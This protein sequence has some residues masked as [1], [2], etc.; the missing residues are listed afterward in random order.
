MQGKLAVNTLM[1]E[2]LWQSETWYQS[3]VENARDVIYTVSE[4]AVIT[5]L[6]P[7]FERITGWPP[8]E[9]IGKPLQS[10]VHPDD[11]PKELELLEHML[12]GRTPPVHE[13]RVRSNS[14]DYWTGEFMITPQFEDGSFVGVVGVGRD[15]T[16]RKRMEEELRIKE[17]AIASSMNAIALADLEGN[18]TYVNPAFL[19][20][21]GYDNAEEVLGKP[22]AKFWKA[23]EHTQAITDALFHRT[24]WRGELVARR[25]D[26]AQCD[27]HVSVNMIEG[28]AGKPLCM[29]SSCVDITEAKRVGR[30]L[31]QSEERY[32]ELVENMTDAIYSIDSEGFITY[33][34]PAIE[35]ILGYH[36]SEMVGRAL[37][38][39]VYREDL[40][41]ANWRFCEAL[42]GNLKPSEYRLVHK[43]GEVRWI[44]ASS[45]PTVVEGTVVGLQGVIA[46]I[47]N[48]KRVE[49]EA[50][51]S[52]P[53]STKNGSHR[54]P[55][56]GNRP[57]L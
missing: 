52:V 34:S 10:I 19:K 44:R 2:R 29:M 15:I 47:T 4:N 23:Q 31:R 55:R 51:R 5:S 17:H 11:W 28:D 39:F 16:W 8:S 9:W 21:W 12:Q 13:V 1:E 24:S 45:K 56:R 22:V 14:G 54:D 18:L 25:K 37:T 57:R 48:T 20:L 36:P 6:N 7:A 3:L 27:V 43:S 50:V 46:D 35:P 26:G 42:S 41:P 38:D 40:A 33:I 53:A 30:E 32:R 49:E